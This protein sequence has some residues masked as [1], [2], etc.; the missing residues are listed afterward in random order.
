MSSQSDWCNQSFQ[1][2]RSAAFFAL[3]FTATSNLF[4]NSVVS[5]SKTLGFVVVRIKHSGVR[6]ALGRPSTV[7]RMRSHS[8]SPSLSRD[9]RSSIKKAKTYNRRDSQMVTHSSTS[10]PVQC[11]CMAERTGCPVLTDLWSYVPIQ[12]FRPL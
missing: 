12:P 2:F 5:P 9:L 4:S 1:S 11:L 10:R 8:R 7:V 3:Q 6:T